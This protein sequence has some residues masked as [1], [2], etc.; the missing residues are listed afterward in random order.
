MAKNLF[1][2]SEDYVK[3]VNDV[4]NEIGIGKYV[5]INVFDMRKSNKDVIKI[6]KTSEPMEV[7][8][9][10]EDMIDVYL[11]EKAFDL[12]EDKDKRFWIETALCQV[13]YDM[14]KS[15]VVIG[16]EPTITVPLGIY[17]KYHDTAIKEMQLAALTVQQI[18][19]KEKQE[20]EEK[21]ALKTKKS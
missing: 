10:G 17:D 9:D 18:K 5:E 3:L 20:K 12:V 6:K 15:K 7:S 14:D 4:A 1:Q 19:D 8:L 21:K 13:A 11:Y 2:A 16:K